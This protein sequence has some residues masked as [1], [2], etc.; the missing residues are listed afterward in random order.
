MEVYSQKHE[1][2]VGIMTKL[3]LG[4]L[5]FVKIKSEHSNKCIAFISGLITNLLEKNIRI[6]K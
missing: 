3:L 4:L 1:G 2:V 5:A 6:G